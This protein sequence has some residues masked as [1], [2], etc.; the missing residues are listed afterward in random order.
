M[1]LVLSRSDVHALLTLPD[2]IAAVE[3]AFAL[4]ADGKTL[5]PGVLGVHVP[6]GGFHVKAAG[7]VGARRY[8]AAKAA[9]MLREAGFDAKYMKGGHSAWKALG[10]AIKP[11]AVGTQEREV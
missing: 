10:S 6:G 8:F 5:G 3:Q 1:T 7:L 9:I 11:H 4:H 2:C